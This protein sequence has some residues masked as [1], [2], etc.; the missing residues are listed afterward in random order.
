MHRKGP[1]TLNFIISAHTHT[2][3]RQTSH[4]QHSLPVKCGISCPADTYSQ[5]THTPSSPQLAELAPWWR[6]TV[7][8]T[9][10]SCWFNPQLRHKCYSYLSSTLIDIYIHICRE[11][12]SCGVFS[13]WYDSRGCDTKGQYGNMILALLF[14]EWG[15]YGVCLK[16]KIITITVKLTYSFPFFL[17]FDL[18]KT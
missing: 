13:I 8:L 5:H 16:K 14:F 11:R 17:S 4:Q 9:V 6:G 3:N 1:F 10:R 12:K 15:G 7:V 18:N 2:H